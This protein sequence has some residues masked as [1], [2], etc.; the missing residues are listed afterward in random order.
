MENDKLLGILKTCNT[1]SINIVVKVSKRCNIRPA[2]EYCY[3]F[4]AQSESPHLDMN[5]QTLENLVKKT[6]GDDKFNKV[7]FVWHGGEP[8]IVGTDFYES[9]VRF[10]KQYN[11]KGIKVINNIQTNAVALNESWIDLFKEYGFNMETSFDAFD[12]DKTRGKTQLVLENILKAKEMGFPPKNIMFICTSRNVNRLREAYDYFDKLGLNFNPSP[13]IALGKGCQAEH[14]AISP[15]QYGNALADLMDYYV[16]ERDERKIKIRFLDAVLKA[17]ITGNQNLCSHGF[18]VYEFVATDHS[19]EIL[20]CA[21]INDPQWSFGNVNKINNFSEIFQTEKYKNYAT[22]CTRRVLQC[23]IDGCEVF[24]YCRGGCA[25]NAMAAGG[26]SKR[27]FYCETYKII[28]NHAL[29]LIGEI[30]EE[31]QRKMQATGGQIPPTKSLN[32]IDER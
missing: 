13:I 5:I 7:S 23:E 10:Q 3:D 8:L 16:K 24:E 32:I 21:K 12:N 25:S 2:C 20:P 19:G 1:G 6:V 26:Y 18:C 11:T 31:K 9:A 27:D 14:L 30:Q 22:E 17:V 28:F 29:D 4:E 15:E